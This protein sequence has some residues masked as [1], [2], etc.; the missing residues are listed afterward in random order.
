MFKLPRI[1]RLLHITSVQ[2]LDLDLYLFAGKKIFLV[3]GLAY[4][5]LI[6]VRVVAV[7]GGN[8]GQGNQHLWCDLKLIYVYYIKVVLLTYY[9]HVMISSMSV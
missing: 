3:H 4:V 6:I 5:L 2:D 7:K 8:I 1:S 9:D